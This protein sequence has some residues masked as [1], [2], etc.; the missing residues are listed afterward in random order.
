MARPELSL[1]ELRGG[2]LNFPS[3]AGIAPKCGMRITEEVFD[4]QVLSMFQVTLAL[5]AEVVGGSLR[6]RSLCEC[7]SCPA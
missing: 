7:S 5:L 6:C 3:R 1:E 4:Q 2:R